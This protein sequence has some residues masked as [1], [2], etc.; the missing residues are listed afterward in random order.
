M[1]LSTQHTIN[2]CCSCILCLWSVSILLY[3]STI[4]I[5]HQYPLYQTL[6]F[7]FCITY[8][9]MLHYDCHLSSSLIMLV[10]EYNTGDLS[11]YQQECLLFSAL[12][13]SLLSS[14]FHCIL[15]LCCLLSP[16]LPLSH[17]NQV[18]VEQYFF[19]VAA[20]LHLLVLDDKDIDVVF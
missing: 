14:H 18:L 9:T 16:H 15:M 5:S 10:L 8:H 19:S 1:I 13:C 11:C 12:C 3:P 6:V 7:R 17:E 2:Y 20:V 4:T